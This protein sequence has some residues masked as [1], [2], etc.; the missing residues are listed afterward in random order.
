MTA[1]LRCEHCKCTASKA[2][3]DRGGWLSA[4][5]HAHHDDVALCVA[6]ITPYSLLEG[7]FL[8]HAWHTLTAI[9]QGAMVDGLDVKA[10]AVLENLADAVE[11][12][13]RQIGK[14]AGRRAAYLIAKGKG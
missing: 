6:C 10:P 7:E 1:E 2:A 5:E 12:L 8:E 4:T 14:N 9:M 3:L 11:S 13:T